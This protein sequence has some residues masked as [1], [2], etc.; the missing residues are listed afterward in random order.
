[1]ERLFGNRHPRKEA[2]DARAGDQWTVSENAV[3]GLRGS[4]F[5]ENALSPIRLAPF[6][7]SPV[8]DVYRRRKRIDAPG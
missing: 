3:I 8:D 2:Q 6:D 5:V 4:W 1:V 7:L